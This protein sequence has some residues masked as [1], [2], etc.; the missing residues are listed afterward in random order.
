MGR[1]VLLSGLEGGEARNY[2]SVSAEGVVQVGGRGEGEL[3]NLLQRWSEP[4]YANS[5]RWCSA[6]KITWASGEVVR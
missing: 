3:S 4:C 5:R 1:A 6:F 2:E